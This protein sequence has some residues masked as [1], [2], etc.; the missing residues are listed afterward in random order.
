MLM[1][2]VQPAMKPNINAATARVLDL[3]GVQTIVARRRRLLRRGA[4]P[5]GDH[6]GGLDDMRRNIDA[7]WPWW[8]LDAARSR[9]S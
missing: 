5:R 9:R 3:A 8:W 1:G 6:D 7:W 2:C 4:Q